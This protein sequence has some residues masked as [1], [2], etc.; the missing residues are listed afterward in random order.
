MWKDRW[1]EGCERMAPPPQMT[2]QQAKFNLG[3]ICMAK[4]WGIHMPEWVG[5]ELLHLWNQQGTEQVRVN[6]SE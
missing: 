2:E 4:V 5:D 3:A 1:E 6:V